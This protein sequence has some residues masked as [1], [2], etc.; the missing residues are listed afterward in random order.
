[1]NARFACW[2]GIATEYD[3]PPLFSAIIRAFLR[4][5]HPPHHLQNFK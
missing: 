5:I 1:M 4:G 2:A 3:R